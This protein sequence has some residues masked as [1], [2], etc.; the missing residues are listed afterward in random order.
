VEEPPDFV[1]CEGVQILE[2][3]GVAVKRVIGLEEDCLRAARR[4]RD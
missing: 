3:R 2:N 4:G 1:Q